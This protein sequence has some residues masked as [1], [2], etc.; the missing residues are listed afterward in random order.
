MCNRYY[1]MDLLFGELEQPFLTHFNCFF[2]NRVVRVCIHNTL[3]WNMLDCSN[4]TDCNVQ[5]HVLLISIKML[6]LN[7]KN[8]FFQKNIYKQEAHNCWVYMPLSYVAVV[9]DNDAFDFVDVYLSYVNKSA[10][11]YTKMRFLCKMW[12]FRTRWSTSDWFNK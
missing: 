12:I 7:N 6:T 3:F 1:W 2:D 9:G 8:F 11:I 5:S 4:W 10:M